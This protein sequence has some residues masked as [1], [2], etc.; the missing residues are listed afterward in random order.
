MTCVVKGNDLAA[1]NY[2]KNRKVTFMREDPDQNQ[3]RNNFL[4]TF[5]SHSIL[6]V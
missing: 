3:Y 2:H 1:L 5:L 4:K 6:S